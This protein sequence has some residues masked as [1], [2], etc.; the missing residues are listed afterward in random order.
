MREWGV[1]VVVR[2]E[3]VVSARLGPDGGA[4]SP[5]SFDIAVI[6][7][8]MGSGMYLIDRLQSAAH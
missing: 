3:R 6:V 5:A 7:A 8:V 4:R 1:S 2:T